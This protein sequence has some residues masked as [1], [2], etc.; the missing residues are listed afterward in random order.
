MYFADDGDLIKIILKRLTGRATFPNI[1]IKGTSIGGFDDIS[2]MDM[3]GKLKGV[4]EKAGVHV[5]G[6]KKK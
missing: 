6:D 1:L 5:R 2:D 4:L 3:E